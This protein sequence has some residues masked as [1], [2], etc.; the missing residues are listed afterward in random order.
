MNIAVTLSNKVLQ[1]PLGRR[2]T[3]GIVWSLAGSVTARLLTLAAS[4][5]VSRQLGKEGF[6]ELGI[7]QS[8]TMM[9]GE[10]AGAGVGLAATKFIAEYRESQPEKAARILSMNVVLAFCTGLVLAIVLACFS[11]QVATHLLKRAELADLLQW[12]SVLLLFSTLY[13]ATLGAITGFEA[14]QRIAIIN[15]FNGVTSLTLQSVL[16]HYFGLNGVMAALAITAALTFLMAYR[17]LRECMKKYR[18]TFDFLSA[19]SELPHLYTFNLPALLS[20]LMVVPVNWTCNLLLVRHLNGYS[21]M[22]LFNAANQW[23]MALLFIPTTIGSVVL[24]ILSSMIGADDIR[25]YRKILTYNLLINVIVSLFIIVAVC[26]LSHLI[27][28]KYGE[29]FAEGALI[30][31]VLMLVAGL[32]AINTI[33]AHAISSIGALW[34]GFSFNL[35]WAVVVISGALLLIPRYGALGLAYANLI[36]YGLHT[37]WQYT[38]VQWRLRRGRPV[39]ASTV[40]TIR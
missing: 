33:I 37:I 26:S 8:T 27:M 35:A 40:P 10:F 38:F 39:T 31:Q 14:F 22:G 5:L 23:R 19:P 7:V 9:L 34:V 15:I 32:M 4:I 28:S 36:A 2:L 18:I 17:T 11:Q 6:G 20:T 16:L 3:T 1:S 21:E 12:G 30:L 25:G 29:G 13:G 24:P